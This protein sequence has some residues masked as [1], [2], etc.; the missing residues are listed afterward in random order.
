MK[1]AHMADL[2][3]GATSDLKL[4][5][6]EYKVL[7]DTF[8]L[9]IKEDVDFVIMA[10]DIF[11][12]NIPD[13]QVVREAVMVFRRFIETGRRIYVVYG[14]HDFS[15]N[16]TSIIDILEAAGLIIRVGKPSV[17]GELLRP[18]VV[19]DK[20]SGVQITG[21]SGRRASL[22]KEAF[23][24]LDREYLQKLGGV[25]IFVFHTGLDE[26]REGNE[27]FEGI[28]Q[29]DLPIGFDYY[30]G[31]HIHR[32]IETKK[33]IKVVYP[34][35][36]FTGWGADLEATAKGSER[37]FFLVEIKEE[38]TIKTEF[39]NM[40]PFEC[41]YK[42]FNATGF[43]ATALNE[44]LAAFSRDGKNEGRLVVLKVFGELS[45]G[46]TSDINF[47]AI[48]ETIMEGGAL[49]LHLNRNQ[50]KTREFAQV[51]VQGE[52]ALEIEEGVLRELAGTVKIRNERL[53]SGSVE[54]AKQLLLQIRSPKMEGET[55]DNYETRII[56][57]AK[58]I[59][60]IGERS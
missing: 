4:R 43:T 57:T 35:P 16:S 56:A 44:K 36:L 58:E 42:E 38:Q 8:R 12:V 55:Q 13:L 24:K 27:R 51:T 45:S 23:C 60:G 6:I 59:L 2:H 9:C 47:A 40:I 17:E 18:T 11:H 25:K 3:L 48:R 20:R 26:V 49:Y 1:F 29:S 33:G 31:G 34:G 5:E 32:M 46:K 21:I 53:K 10:G 52:S 30:A 28:S 50:L 14:S 15:P 22:E 54:I 37:G 41:V 19:T 39:K 7:D